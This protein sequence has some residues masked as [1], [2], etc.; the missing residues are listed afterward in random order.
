MISEPPT[1]CLALETVL[2]NWWLGSNTRDLFQ[3][4]TI[5][6]LINTKT[7]REDTL[8]S[9]SLREKWIFLPTSVNLKSI[10]IVLPICIIF[11]FVGSPGSLLL[12]FFASCPKRWHCPLR[13]QWAWQLRIKWSSRARKWLSKWKG[14]WGWDSKVDPVVVMLLSHGALTVGKGSADYA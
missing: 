10:S 2:V 9:V 14:W 13:W 5:F 4:S 1:G 11:T 3:W 6:S 7:S 8:I 12:G